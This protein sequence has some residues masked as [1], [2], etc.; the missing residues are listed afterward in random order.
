MIS[1]SNSLNDNSQTHALT[2]YDNSCSALGSVTVNT[3]GAP[4]GAFLYGTLSSSVTLSAGGTYYIMSNETNCGDW[5]YDGDTIITTTSAATSVVAA[6][7]GCQTGGSFNRTYVPV[8]FKY[9]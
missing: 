2:I 6:F 1:L 7:G 9:H 3:S 5:W 4:A 8:D